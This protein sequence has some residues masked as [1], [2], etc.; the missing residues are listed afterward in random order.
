MIKEGSRQRKVKSANSGFFGR[1]F[2]LLKN[3]APLREN[4]LWAI[5]AGSFF[6]Q[7]AVSGSL[8]V[9]LIYLTEN[10]GLSAF[11]AVILSSMNPFT[12]IF[13]HLFSGKVIRILGPKKSASCGIFL[14]AALPLLFAFA[15]SWVLIAVGYIFL[16]SAFGAFFNGVSTFISVNTP[17][18]R[19]AEFLG[20]LSS[21]RAFGS[22]L[23]P[24]VAGIA[25]LLSFRVMYFSM[26]LILVLSGFIVVLFAKEKSY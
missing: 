2:P 20:F 4:G 21:I 7:M 9:I 26:G 23:G 15:D 18:E 16:G 5:Y 14:T 22:M 25:A 12:Q 13:S 11:V 6:R 17:P 1:F 3:P 19:R 10:V 8:S 24:I